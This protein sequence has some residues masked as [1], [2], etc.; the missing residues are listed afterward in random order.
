M[1]L[2][3][4]CRLGWFP[5]RLMRE[6]A[7]PLEATTVVARWVARVVV[8][9]VAAVRVRVVEAMV[10]AATA[11]AMVATAMASMLCLCRQPSTP[12]RRSEHLQ[13]CW[14]RRK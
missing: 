2:S 7:L 14:F 5:M 4:G 6:G 12:P 11:A 8:A 3:T 1:R 13:L 10:A 9:R